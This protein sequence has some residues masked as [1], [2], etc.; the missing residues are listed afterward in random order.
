M[1]LWDCAGE[2]F[3]SKSRLRPASEMCLVKLILVFVVT[4]VWPTDTHGKK[5]NNFHHRPYDA[6]CPPRVSLAAELLLANAA[7]KMNLKEFPLN[8]AA[9]SWDTAVGGQRPL[10]LAHMVKSSRVLEL[11]MKLCVTCSACMVLELMIQ[12]FLIVLTCRVL[13]SDFH[14][15]TAKQVTLLPPVLL[16]FCSL[17]PPPS[18]IWTQVIHDFIEGASLCLHCF[19]CSMTALH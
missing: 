7:S 19:L 4:H 12:L 17:V 6:V 13:L 1:W 10:W 15:Y 3:T 18:W 14:D 9:T 16:I 2:K 8:W 11:R 5:Q